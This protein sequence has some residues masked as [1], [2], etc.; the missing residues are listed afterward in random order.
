MVAAKAKASGAR[1]CMPGRSPKAEG[2]RPKETRNPK[3]EVGSPKPEGRR[4]K[5]GRSPKAEARTAAAVP[6]QRRA[7]SYALSPLRTSAFGLLSAFGLRTSA[8]PS[9][10]HLRL[11]QLL[12][13]Q[14]LQISIGA[15]GE[16]I[17]A[18]GLA[19]LPQPLHEVLH[20]L[21]IRLEPETAEGHL[22]R[23]PGFRIHQAQVAE[24]PGRQFIRRENLHQV[25]LKAAAD[26][27]V[28]P[29]LVTRRVEEI[30]Q[31]DRHPRLPRL[32]RA[33]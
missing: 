2:R 6:P 32:E 19:K 9:S 16:E 4:P 30:A 1:K 15:G 3:A 8:F 28:Q 29:G 33:S 5:E 18:T 17:N 10:P 21:P 7:S 27:R 23:G 31:H 20:R 24:R 26:Q 22:L 12:Q 13:Q 14:F 11:A 25:H